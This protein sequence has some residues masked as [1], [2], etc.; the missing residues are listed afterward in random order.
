MQAK[1]WVNATQMEMLHTFYHH[2]PVIQ[3]ARKFLLNTL[4][5]HGIEITSGQK[6]TTDDFQYVIDQYWVPFASKLFDHLKMFGLCPIRFITV[7]DKLPLKT[8]SKAI[9]V[10]YVLPYGSYTLEVVRDKDY[11]ATYV[12]YPKDNALMESRPDKECMVLVS[13]QYEPSVNGCLQSPLLSLFP[14]YSFSQQMHQYALHTEYIRSHP[15]LITETKPE[16]QGGTEAVAMEMFGDADAY[17]NR[18]EASYHKNRSRVQEFQRQQNLAAAMNGKQ[19]RDHR[20]E[21]DPFTGQKR[22][23]ARQGQAWE[24]S[25]FVLPE[26][27]RLCGHINPQ[28]RGD[29]L[30]MEL[31][32][33][34]LICGIMGVPR[35]LLIPDKGGGLNVNVSDI[36]YKLFMRTMDAVRS[37][38]VSHLNTV[39]R[40]IY[41]ED[42]DINL[43]FTTMHSVEQLNAIAPFVQPET[44]GKFLLQSVGI[45]EDALCVQPLPEPQSVAE[46]EREAVR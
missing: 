28:A 2:D 30:Q 5:S 13:R 41:Q 33:Y 32:R 20:Y 45:P 1:T 19:C 6:K 4:L 25:V 8:T 40:S 35:S 7:K 21:I 12:V 27:H 44:L 31:A 23:R 22:K 34:D 29:L 36:T 9:K 16:T 42:A 17:M 24:E 11:R 14:S 43:P 15:P 39:Y 37:E 38:L 26:G 18:D 10:P 3:I 46:S